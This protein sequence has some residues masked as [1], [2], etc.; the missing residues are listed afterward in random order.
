[1]NLMTFVRLLV[2]VVI[3]GTAISLG[4]GALGVGQVDAPDPTFFL[5]RRAL[6]D[7]MPDGQLDPTGKMGYRL[8]DQTNGQVKSLALPEGETWSLLS[9]SPWRDKDGNLLAAGRWVSRGDG[10]EEFCGIGCL[11][12]P[13]S[14]V[15]SRITLD[16]LPTG[17]PCWVTARPGE[18]LFSAGDGQL[19]RCKIIGHDQ[20]QRADDSRHFL[21]KTQESVVHARAITWKAEM[22]GTDVA[23]LADPAV[24]SEPDNRHL[25]FVS[26]GIQ[27][28]RGG[29]RRNLTTQLWWLVMDDD[30]NGDRQRG[31]PDGG[32][33]VRRPKWTS[34]ERLPNVVARADGK[35]SLVYLTRLRAEKPRGNFDR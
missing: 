10:A 11:S 31:P 21:P 26:L 1:M 23:G 33:A 34:F 15:K 18:V 30:G 19:Y 27:E 5:A 4:A 12:L 14:T 16:V 24:L 7:A 17:K 22:P 35:F 6:E 3:G 13:S 28:Q 9:V 8:V 2:L 32:R 20:D 25:V 29:R